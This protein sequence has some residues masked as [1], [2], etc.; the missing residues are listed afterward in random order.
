MSGRVSTSYFST[1]VVTFAPATRT[2]AATAAATR[3][4]S[5]GEHDAA[6]RTSATDQTDTRLSTST[7]RCVVRCGLLSASIARR[8][9]R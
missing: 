1:C 6:A 9:R 4:R 3:R 2:I 7:S 5:S 8:S